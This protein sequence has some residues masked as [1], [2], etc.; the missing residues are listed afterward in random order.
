VFFQRNSAWFNFYGTDL[1]I[2]K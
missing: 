1:I 2:N